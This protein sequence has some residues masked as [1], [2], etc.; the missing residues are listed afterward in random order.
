MPPW[1]YE[2]LTNAELLRRCV[3]LGV[4]TLRYLS[5]ESA[6]QFVAIYRDYQPPFDGAEHLTIPDRPEGDYPPRETFRSPSK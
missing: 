1:P 5:P 2:R 3:I 4:R 6:K